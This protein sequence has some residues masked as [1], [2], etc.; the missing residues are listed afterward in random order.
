MLVAAI[1]VLGIAIVRRIAGVWVEWMADEAAGDGPGLQAVILGLAFL[2]ASPLVL[3]VA[4]TGW[5]GRRVRRGDRFP[6]A[7]LPLLRDTAV[8][9]GA[10]A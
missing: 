5:L 9:V 3:L 10:A 7:G 8:V 1:G 2:L 6:P 4:Y